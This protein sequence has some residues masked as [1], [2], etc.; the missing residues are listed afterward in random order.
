MSEPIPTPTDGACAG[1][2]AAY[3]AQDATL[4]WR[5]VAKLAGIDPC[6]YSV[7]PAWSR[8]RAVAYPWARRRG[9]SI[10]A[11]AHGRGGYKGRR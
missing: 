6:P 9:W 2:R 11:R 5:Q 4:T 8:A 10:P 7:T 1:W 3:H